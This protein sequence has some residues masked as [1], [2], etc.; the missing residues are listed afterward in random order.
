M[1][2]RKSPIVAV[3]CCSK[4]VQDWLCLF[5]QSSVC[6]VEKQEVDTDTLSHGCTIGK[7]HNDPATGGLPGAALR[8]KT[9]CRK[10]QL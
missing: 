3:R 7:T 1:A 5:C 10:E 6:V 2:N 9:G 4:P 8:R